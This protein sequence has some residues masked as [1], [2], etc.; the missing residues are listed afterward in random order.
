MLFLIEKDSA[1]RVPRDC[2]LEEAQEVATQFPVHVVKEDGSTQSLADYMAAQEPVTGEQVVV[3]EP[4]ARER[5]VVVADPDAP[6]V[7][8][9]G[10]EQPAA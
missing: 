7:E 5:D 2:S 1:T 8:D 3:I 6:A 9:Q 10:G 4:E